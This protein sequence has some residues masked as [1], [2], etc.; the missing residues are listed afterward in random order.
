M[1]AGAKRSRQVCFVHLAYSPKKC[2]T[3]R[4]T[5][6]CLSIYNLGVYSI[7]YIQKA[8]RELGSAL[9]CQRSGSSESPIRKV[10]PSAY[11]CSLIYRPTFPEALAE[12]AIQ[13]CI[14]FRSAL[15]LSIWQVK[16]INSRRGREPQHEFIKPIC[17]H[18]G[19]QNVK[20]WMASRATSC[21]RG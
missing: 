19:G 2:E 6:G 20:V 4:F 16:E 18:L 1:F 15:A 5:C 14:A 10:S 7:H 21:M 13:G 3:A 8:A 9:S 17:G 12:L 11:A